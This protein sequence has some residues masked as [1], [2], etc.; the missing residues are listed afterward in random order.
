MILFGNSAKE[1][2]LIK[3]YHEHYENLKNNYEIYKT[4][5]KNVLK[6]ENKYKNQ[7]SSFE[8]K[9][10]SLHEINSSILKTK[11]T[12]NMIGYPKVLS[13]E[14]YDNYVLYN[15]CNE[16]INLLK[17][18]IE[19]GYEIFVNYEPKQITT[20]MLLFQDIHKVPGYKVYQDNDKLHMEEEIKTLQAKIQEFS[21]DQID[22][23]HNLTGWK[24]DIEK[25]LKRLVQFEEDHASIKQS[26]F[27][28]IDDMRK[29]KKEFFETKNKMDTFY[30]NN[31]KDEKETLNNIYLSFSSK[32]KKSLE[33]KQNSFTNENFTM[34]C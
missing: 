5:Q 25:R 11:N 10:K 8:S 1:R 12:I 23:F 26:I 18:K 3:Q 2:E 29:T 32:T 33:K 9:R 19:K 14:E 24:H 4:L 7:I 6:I 27:K 34:W 16:K 20:N 30:N 31:L 13:K 17:S 28:H 22:F 15:E 21:P